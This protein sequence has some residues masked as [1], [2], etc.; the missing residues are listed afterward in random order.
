MAV[1]IASAATDA[2][3]TVSFDLTSTTLFDVRADVTP[4]EWHPTTEQRI[5]NGSGAFLI[6]RSADI[7]M[8][9]KDSGASFISVDI[10]QFGI[11]QY[12]FPQG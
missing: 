11:A 1:D 4:D 3:F 12:D 7:R 10:K 6:L 5:F 9:Y 2:S 8:T